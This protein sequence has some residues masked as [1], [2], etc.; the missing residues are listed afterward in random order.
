LGETRVTHEMLL[1]LAAGTDERADRL[2]GRVRQQFEP[3][4]PIL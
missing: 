3:Y 2:I 1:R 4:W